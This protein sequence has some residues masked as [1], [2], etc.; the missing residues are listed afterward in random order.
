MRFAGVA[1]DEPQGSTDGRDAKR[2]A[3]NSACVEHRLTGPVLFECKGENYGEFVLPDH[4]S[5]GDYPELD[6]FDLVDEI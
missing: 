3:N 6:P 4:C 2:V 5:V 1:L